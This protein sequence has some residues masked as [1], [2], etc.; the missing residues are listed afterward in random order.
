MSNN[1]VSQVHQFTGP[2]NQGTE[3]ESIA[4]NME[5]SVSEMQMGVVGSVGY[6]SSHPVSHQLISDN[7]LPQRVGSIDMQMGKTETKANDTLQSDQYL[8]NQI[9]HLGPMLNM[10]Q[11]SAS[12]K[13][14]APMEPISINSISEQLSLK[15]MAQ[16]QHRPWLH[17]MP[18]PNKKIVQLETMPNSPGSHNSPTFNKKMVKM[19]SFSNKS[20]SQRTPSQKGQSARIQ[21]PSKVSTE[22]SESVRS[23]MREQLASAFSLVNQQENKPSHNLNNCSSQGNLQPG[24]H[25]DP[26]TIV[27]HENVSSGDNNLSEQKNDKEKGECQNILANVGNDDSALTSIGDGREFQSGNLLSYNDVSFSENFFVKDE[28][29]QG[30]GLSWVLESDIEMVGRKKMQNAE[31]E[32]SG[33]EE[34]AGDKLEQTYQSPENL[35][36]K[37]EAELF[38]LFGGVN[39][40]YKEKGRS[41]LFNLK[42]RNN[43]ELRERVMRGEISPERLCSMTAEELASKELSEWRMA[44]AEELAQMVVLPDSDVDIRRLVRKTHKGEFQVEVEQDDSLPMDISGGSS[45]VAQ[46][47]PKRKE[48]EVPPSK[49]DGDKGDLNSLGDRST[50]CTF[51]IIPSCEANDLIEGLMVDDGLKDAEFLPPIVSLD[52][53]MESLDS[54]PPFDNLPLDDSERRT[55]VSEKDDSEVGSGS[56]SLDRSP[57]DVDASSEKC[58]NTNTDDDDAKPGDS[59]ADLKSSG[60]CAEAESR[61]NLDDVKFKECL[62]NV[63]SRDSVLKTETSLSP[64]PKGEHVWGGLVQLNISTSATVIALFKSGEKTSANEWPGFLEIKGRVRLDAFEKFLQEL[65]LSRSRAVMVVHFVIKDQSSESESAAL[66]EVADSYIVDERVGFAE[67]ASGVELYFCPPHNKTVERLGKI[68]QKEHIEALNA[69]DNGLIGVIVWRKLST[70]SPKSSSH[71]KHTSKKHHITS[72]RHQDSSLNSNFTPKQALPHLATTNY[73]PSPADDDDEDDVPPGFGPPAARGDE[74]DLPEFN[75]SGGSNQPLPNISARNPSRGAVPAPYHPLNTC[76]VEQVRELIHK[77]GQNN[78]SAIPPGNWK[79]KGVS[80][81]GVQHW[82]D[83]DDDDIPEWQ[84]QVPTQH[85]PNFQQPMLRPHVQNQPHFGLVPPQ[86]A[87][88][89]M[90][91]PVNGPENMALWQQ[92]QQQQGTWWAPPAPGNGLRPSNIGCQPDVGQ[93][94]GASGRG[95]VNQPGMVW[96]QNTPK[97]RGF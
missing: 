33:H 36:F 71:H 13:R 94:Y 63:K 46:S 9:G 26:E 51:T 50:S 62:V 29:L 53:F 28:L 31:K 65:P 11:V 4:N 21:P 52:E 69:I 23:K 93:M 54:E 66:Q 74:D 18:A 80:G 27:S 97:S 96:Q 79:D 76:P 83:D 72:R 16:P 3:L 7:P 82:N 8:T 58:D 40:K 42:D 43:P 60:P 61:E 67:P 24:D 25:V 49:S 64:T 20:G 95:I 87:H 19:D 32:K 56:K 55:P 57:K 6:I 59:Q 78:T 41:L 34:V 85:V 81:V 92:Q 84:P 39:K 15:R 45:S 44:K 1:L 77:Y 90:Q 2:S 70:T 12:F 30:N 48:K 86:P 37:I 35:A 91:P 5:S 47:W 88:Q 14:K 75:F 22:S 38:K 10:E 89:A 68:I 17:Q 73:R